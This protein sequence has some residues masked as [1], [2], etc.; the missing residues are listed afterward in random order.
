[1]NIERSGG[2]ANIEGWKFGTVKV[3]SFAGRNPA[4]RWN[5]VCERCSSSWTEQHY[6]LTQGEYHCKNMA[7]TLGRVQA[8]R[9]KQT[10]HEPEIETPVPIPA[11]VPKV[12]DEYRRYREQ[13]K[14]W[15]ME[16]DLGSSTDF[17]MLSFEQKGRIMAPVI[18]AE[19]QREIE[20][21]AASIEA[22]ERERMRRQYGI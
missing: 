18:E 7:C 6:R 3:L 5:V 16:K 20:A 13:M 2:F 4:P 21:F 1:M 17:E 22:H 14:V 15:G 8:P 19:R 12:S 9:A 10:E 11:P